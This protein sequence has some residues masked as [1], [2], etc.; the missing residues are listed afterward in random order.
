MGGVSRVKM[1]E[2][3]RCGP[4][5]EFSDAQSVCSW[6]GREHHS[7]TDIQMHTVISAT[8]RPGLCP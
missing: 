1:G 6:S 4:L 2:E 7:L 8:N 3:M 5:D